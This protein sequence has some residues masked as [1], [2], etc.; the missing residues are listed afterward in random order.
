MGLLCKEF[1]QVCCIET[2]LETQENLFLGDEIS[3]AIARKVNPTIRSEERAKALTKTS[4]NAS[5]WD[6]YLRALDLYN[7][8]SETNIEK[9]GFKTNLQNISNESEIKRKEKF[10][11]YVFIKNQCCS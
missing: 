8:R 2:A 5:A 4:T 11:F 9:Y 6:T 1:Q 7:K 10:S 3:L